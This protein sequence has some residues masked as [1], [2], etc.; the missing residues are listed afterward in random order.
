MGTNAVSLRMR[1]IRKGIEPA[2]NILLRDVLG[3]VAQKHG[4]SIWEIKAKSRSGAVTRAR[5]E[6]FFRA[7]KE[8]SH[9]CKTIGYYCQ[10]DHGSVLYGAARH[11]V[12]NN[13]PIPRGSTAQLHKVI[14][15]RPDYQ[16]NPTQKGKQKDE[17]TK[18]QCAN[19]P[20]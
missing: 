2:R 6:F 19:H 1:R 14:H 5:H 18:D 15:F 11:A 12:M 17:Q 4:L 9:S 10:S 13:V 20:I 16:F 7:L 3:E 8:T